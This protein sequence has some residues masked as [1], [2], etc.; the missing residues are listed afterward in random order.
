MKKLRKY[1]ST[2]LLFGFATVLNLFGTVA[3]F[4]QHKP[5]DGTFG[6]VCGIFCAIWFYDNLS[7]DIA[8]YNR[9]NNIEQLPQKD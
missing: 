4:L 2:T 5:F 9:N 3:L 8:K 6:V 7:Q 1:R